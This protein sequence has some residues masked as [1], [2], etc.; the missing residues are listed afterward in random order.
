MSKR[1]L[2]AVM[3]AILSI[4]SVSAQETKEEFVQRYNLLVNR[5]GYAGVGVETL[6][7]K[8]EAAYPED[9]DMLS[10]K[11]MFYLTKSS[12][13]S[14]EQLD[15]DKYM[16]QKPVLT[17]KDSLG[18]PVN[19]FQVTKY[20]DEMFGEALTYMDKAIALQPDALDLR[21]VKISS[22]IAYE[23]DSPDMATAEIISLID[24]NASQHPAWTYVGME[25]VDKE[26]FDASIQKLCID[27]FN[28]GGEKCFEEFKNISERML[29][30]DAKNPLFLNNVGTYYLVSQHNNK[31]A[32]KYYKKVLKVQPGDMTA[33][34]NI[35]LLSRNSRDTKLEKKY[36]KEVIKYTED[37]NEKTSASLRLEALGK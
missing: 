1:I 22:Y 14:V 31:L 2:V 23:G 9:V 30:Y 21:Y 28:I 24:Y 17:L 12:S 16:G 18:N 3:T 5:M 13:S 11:F 8:W 36:L 4:T 15:Q 7:D 19:Y 6:L 32:L 10:G 29:L 25:K 34:K 33:L 26:V 27:L 37:E 20:E 35:I